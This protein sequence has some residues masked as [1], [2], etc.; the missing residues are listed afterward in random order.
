MRAMAATTTSVTFATLPTR[1]MTYL[2][3]CCHIFHSACIGNWIKV[4]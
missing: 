1:L 3:P 4:C 2:L